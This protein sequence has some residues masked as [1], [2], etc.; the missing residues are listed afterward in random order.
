MISRQ[1]NCSHVRVAT[2]VC[3]RNG[4][5]SSLR[6]GALATALSVCTAAGKHGMFIVPSDNR[7]NLSCF[8]KGESLGMRFG[9]GGSQPC[10]WQQPCLLL[11]IGSPSPEAAAPVLLLLLTPPAL[12]CAFCSFLHLQEGAGRSCWE[13]K[14]IMGFIF[15]IWGRAV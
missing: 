5:P 9:Q 13:E 11:R 15:L 2:I 6:L 8:L 14:D 7:G 4:S 1:Y 10:C 12:T 3:F